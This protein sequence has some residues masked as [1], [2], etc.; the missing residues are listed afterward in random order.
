MIT[1]NTSVELHPTSALTSLEKLVYKV[2]FILY[3]APIKSPK[4]TI[5][6]STLLNTRTVCVFVFDV[7][8][9]GNLAV[10]FNWK[11][12]KFYTNRITELFD[13][14]LTLKYRVTGEIGNDGQAAKAIIW[15]C[16]TDIAKYA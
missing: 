3:P 9:F 4:L 1:A 7:R 8:I 5:H 15:V 11:L 12:P 6:P 10:V 16:W 14:L 13:M 2:T